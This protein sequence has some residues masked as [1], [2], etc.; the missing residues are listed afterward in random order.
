MHPLGTLIPL[1][2]RVKADVL[3]LMSGA[4]AAVVTVLSAWPTSLG[5]KP[6]KG[7]YCRELAKY[8]LESTG[9]VA[10][11]PVESPITLSQLFAWLL[12]ILLN[13]Q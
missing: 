2:R 12:L 5:S 6:A 13:N 10:L 1:G 9:E 7:V 4:A 11:F 3:L 8:I